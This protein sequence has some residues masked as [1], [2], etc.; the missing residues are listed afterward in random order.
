[1]EGGNLVAVTVKTEVVVEPD[2]DGFHG[3]TPA[4]KGLYVEGTTVSETFSAL[5]EA[6]ECYL[7]SIAKHSDPLP[8]GV[9]IEV[10]ESERMTL[11]WPTTK[12]LGTRLKTLQSNVSSPR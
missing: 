9:E 5:R 2:G 7:E 3:Y 11:T 1:M 12:D 10:E 6:V 8:E 4:L